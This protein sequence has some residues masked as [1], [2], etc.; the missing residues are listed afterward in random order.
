MM[1]E[2]LEGDGHDAE[3]AFLV[4]RRVAGVGLEVG[5][6]TVAVMRLC[7]IFDSLACLGTV[8]VCVRVISLS[9]ITGI[10]LLRW[11]TGFTLQSDGRVNR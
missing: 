9:L 5:L 11:N 1:A 4:D 2:V 3:G 8:T 10:S 7:L 6:G